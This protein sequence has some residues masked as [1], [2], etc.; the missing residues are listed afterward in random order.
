VEAEEEEAVASS[1]TAQSSSA[2]RLSHTMVPP[3]SPAHPLRPLIP[4][5]TERSVGCTL[6]CARASTGGQSTCSSGVPQVGGSGT[7]V[8]VSP[9]TGV[10]FQCTGLTNHPRIAWTPL[11]GSLPVDLTGVVL[12]WCA[13]DLL[14]NPSVSIAGGITMIQSAWGSSSVAVG[15]LPLTITAQSLTGTGATIGGINTPTLTLNVLDLSLESTSVVS[16][17]T[18]MTVVGQIF[19]IGGSK[20]QATSSPSQLIITAPYEA[21]RAVAAAAVSSS[22][23]HPPDLSLCCCAVAVV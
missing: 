20:I 19:L 1:S 9:V 14:A 4:S 2:S 11:N 12:T 3:S 16:F 13:L 18:A 7:W 23:S 5:R 15:G 21:P 8:D 10:R 17:G 22:L 6:A